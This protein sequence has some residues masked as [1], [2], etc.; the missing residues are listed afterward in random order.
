MSVFKHP[1]KPKKIKAELKSALK[2]VG[3]PA[4]LHC[5]QRFWAEQPLSPGCNQHL[6]KQ[7]A[8]CCKVC[9]LKQPKPHNQRL[10]G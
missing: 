10:P 3:P 8:K 7:G 9:H 6:Y 5:L 1:L 2:E 4:V